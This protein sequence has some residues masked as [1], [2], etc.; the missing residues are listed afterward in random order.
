M[1]MS[2]PKSSK[3]VPQS[4]SDCLT[5]A[6]G[7]FAP[8]SLDEMEAVKL[9]NRTDSKYLTDIATLLKVLADAA[10]QGYRALLADKR[11]IVPYD[12]VYFD[13]EELKMFTDHRNRKLVRQK[14][15][16]RCYLSS[17]LSFLEIKR[18]NNHGRTK[19]KRIG[20]PRTDFEDFRS[21]AEASAYLA[22]HSAFT[23]DKLRPE[24]HTRF[25]R[26]TLVNPEMTERL[27]IDT[28]LHFHNVRSG[29]DATLGDAVIIELK[30][31]GRA[32]SR[33]KSILLRHRVKPFR[34]SKY[35]IAVTLTDPA[36]RVGRFKLKLKKINK[37]AKTL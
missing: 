34:I 23:A 31:D 1:N 25:H 26:I 10:G 18:K 30:Q 21:N 13:T 32:E 20:I 9:M 36:A 37:I 19:K 5:A 33:M 22:S 6:V 28:Q 24:L 2:S 11:N 4:P 27:T 35:C 7:R 14:V 17:G 8:I 29:L 3:T 12:S 15:R 16:T